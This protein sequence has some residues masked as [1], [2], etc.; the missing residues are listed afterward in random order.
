MAID[1]EEGTK[2]S[3]TELNQEMV[4]MEQQAEA[5]LEAAQRYFRARLS[6]QLVFRRADGTIIRKTGFLDGLKNNPFQ[7]RDPENVSVSLQ[8]ERAL[9]TLIV[10]GKR[11][12][13]KSE[14]RYCNIR[15]FS[16]FGN[17]WVM[18]FWYN[19]E[20]TGL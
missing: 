15:L 11:K 13:D 14:H 19:Y 9:V 4:Q 10:V 16:R 20:I 17:E 7:K 18:E 2:R 5:G 8:G 12:D 3:L 6:D 1:D